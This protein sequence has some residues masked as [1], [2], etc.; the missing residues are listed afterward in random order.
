MPQMSST[1]GQATWLTAFLVSTARDEH[2]HR[3]HGEGQ[4]PDL[5]IEPHG[6][7]HE[8]QQAH[9]RERPGRG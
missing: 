6:A 1:V 9:Q 2:E 8:R 3:R 4:E 7:D 5:E